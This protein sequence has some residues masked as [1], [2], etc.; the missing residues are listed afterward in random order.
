[1][2]RYYR[3]YMPIIYIILNIYLLCYNLKFTS[4]KNINIINKKNIIIALIIFFLFMFLIYF[5][6]LKSISYISYYLFKA[7]TALIVNI[8]ILFFI[9][10]FT[11]KNLGLLFSFI[12]AFFTSIYISFLLKSNVKMPILKLSLFYSFTL[13][14][15]TLILTIF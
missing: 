11:L 9:Y 5:I 15:L 8:I 3:I 12:Y 10:F 13:S 6:I 4:F 14:I 2:K 1:M 7:Q